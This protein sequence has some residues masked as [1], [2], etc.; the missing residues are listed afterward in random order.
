M[1][2][3]G[4]GDPVQNGQGTGWADDTEPILAPAGLT[5]TEVS[6]VRKKEK[7]SCS[8]ATASYERISRSVAD[9]TA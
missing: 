6:T 8:M 4:L 3:F 1:R 5:W 7:P 2:V 9:E